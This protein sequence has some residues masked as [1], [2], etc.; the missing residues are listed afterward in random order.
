V[1]VRALVNGL[2]AG[3]GAGVSPDAAAGDKGE[4][5]RVC[6]L[7]EL[8]IGDTR[9]TDAGLDDVARLLEHNTELV[10]LNLNAN[11][12][13]TYRGWRRLGKALRKNERLHTLTLDFNKIGDE[14]MAAIAAGL[15]LNSTLR[16]LD[17]EQTGLTEGGGRVLLELLKCNTAILELT[18]MPGN[19]ISHK[20][21]G[22]MR[23]YL[24][25]NNTAS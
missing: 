22:E 7:K 13:I 10:S 12:G 20:L 4:A 2:L 16:T 21:L 25:L 3:R 24:A 11:P 8:D 1:G 19:V 23:N 6:S 5:A 17:L 9:L 14:G 18:A 15:R